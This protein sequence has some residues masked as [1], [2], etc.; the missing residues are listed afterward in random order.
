MPVHRAHILEAHLLE[1]GGMVD[2]AAD[3]LLAALQHPHHARAHHRD[4]FQRG[5]HLGLGMEILGV[6]AQAGQVVGDLAHIF[7]DGHFVVV[8]DDDQ[9]IEHPDVVHALVDH[10]AGERAVADDGHHLARLPLDLFGTG[11]ADGNRQR[12]AA[13]AGNKRVAVAFGRVGKAGDAVFL[14]QLS[15]PG[16]AAGQQLVGIALVAHIEHNFILRQ[17]QCPVQRDRQLHHAQVG[18]KM[19]AGG[20][21]ALDQEAADL[22]AQDGQFLRKQLF[23]ITWPPDAAQQWIPHCGTPLVFLSCGAPWHRQYSSFP[24]SPGS[25]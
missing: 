5:L 9:V 25:A 6:G 20:G 14:A 12:G 10:A 18:G 4:A 21:N 13:V 17:A 22:V 2:A 7:R 19:S 23:D 3:D 15:K 24:V 16:A 11:N 8:E 1:H